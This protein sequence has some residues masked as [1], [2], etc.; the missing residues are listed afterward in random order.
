M[1]LLVIRASQ[2]RIFILFT[3]AS[4]FFSFQNDFVKCV[5]TEEGCSAIMA[6]TF[7]KMHLKLCASR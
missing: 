2:Q 3:D 6:V 4:F 5:K 1:F 7:N